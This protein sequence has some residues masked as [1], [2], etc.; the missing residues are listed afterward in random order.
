[1][2]TIP[3]V[4]RATVILCNGHLSALCGS[5]AAA[6]KRPL[7]LGY[8]DLEAYL[9]EYKRPDSLQIGKKVLLQAVIK[10]VKAALEVYRFE[11]NWEASRDQRSE[12]RDRG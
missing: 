12:I 9:H 6:W 11:Q 7:S 8:A 4:R 2:L 3:I 1:M 10:T 5:G